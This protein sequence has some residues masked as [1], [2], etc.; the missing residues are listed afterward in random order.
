MPRFIL[1]Q[2]ISEPIII[3]T[4]SSKVSMEKVSNSKR[5]KHGWTI[6][7]KETRMQ[8]SLFPKVYQELLTADRNVT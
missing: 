4:D 1:F 3:Y 8:T 2:E 6:F 7:P 5:V